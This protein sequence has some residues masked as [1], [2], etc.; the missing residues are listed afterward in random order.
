MAVVDTAP[1]WTL[2]QIAGLAFSFFMLASYFGAKYVDQYVADSQ[3]EQVG[4]CIKCGGLY[5]GD[6]K[7]CPE[8]DCPSSFAAAPSKE[9]SSPPA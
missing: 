8:S 2:D 7:P 9:T 4:V 6:D 3:R 1:E 5:E